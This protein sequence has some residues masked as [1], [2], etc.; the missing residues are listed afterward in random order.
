MRKVITDSGSVTSM[1]VA[2]VQVE[3]HKDDCRPYGD[4]DDDVFKNRS[5]SE[6]VLAAI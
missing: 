2:L 1:G 3:Q 4:G 6:N 5:G